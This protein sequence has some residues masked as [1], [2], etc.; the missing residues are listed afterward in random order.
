MAERSI[1]CYNP[2]IPPEREVRQRVEAL[3][4]EKRGSLSQVRFAQTFIL[5]CSCGA[6]TVTSDTAAPG[7]FSG[8]HA[9]CREAA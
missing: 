5:T 3:I 4:A 8:E 6:L 1:Y 9:P 7:R 2:V